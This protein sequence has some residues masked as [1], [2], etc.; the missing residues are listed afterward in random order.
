MGF[1]KGKIV[2]VVKKAPL[3]D[4]VEYEIMGY[5]ISLRK[6]ESRMVIV[7]PITENLKIPVNHFNG[8]TDEAQR[9]KTLEDKGRF[10]HV[11]FVGN[12]NCGKTTLFNH[13]SGSHERVGNYGGVTVEAKKAS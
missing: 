10:I 4:P 2:T 7:I 1:V 6:S 9:I 11:A 8:T 3:M 13:A 5:N 12:P